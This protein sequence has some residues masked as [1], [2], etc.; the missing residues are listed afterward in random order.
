MVKLYTDK[1]CS[2]GVCLTADPLFFSSAEL[3]DSDGGSDSR[4]E[5]EAG[6][7][8]SVEV[9]VHAADLLGLIV[10]DSVKCQHAVLLVQ[11]NPDAF[12]FGSDQRGL[13]PIM[14][15]GEGLAGPV[16]APGL[17]VVTQPGAVVR[18]RA[19]HVLIRHANRHLQ[20]A[21]QCHETKGIIQ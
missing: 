1:D 12:G 20:T 15:Q 7:Q 17:W 8:R 3:T 14:P 21:N 19:L 18:R 4:P 2:R 16:E 13:F 11:I 10:R 6:E 9:R 5:A